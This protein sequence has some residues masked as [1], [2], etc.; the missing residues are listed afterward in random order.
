MRQTDPTDLQMVERYG[1]RAEPIVETWEPIEE[2]EV[3]E[4]QPPR[5]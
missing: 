2:A 4:E 1:L 5:V 3:V